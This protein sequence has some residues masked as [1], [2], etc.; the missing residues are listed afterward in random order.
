[1]SSLD[2][3]E[4]D[5]NFKEQRNAVRKQVR[6]QRPARAAVERKKTARLLPASAT[7]PLAHA[8]RK[9]PLEKLS[10]GPHEG[11]RPHPSSSR[12]AWSGS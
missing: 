3:K 5:C 4:S 2:C 11:S 8:S 12:A 10:H 9:C 1:M 7:F 6:A